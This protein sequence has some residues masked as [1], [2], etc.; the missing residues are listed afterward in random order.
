MAVSAETV[1]ARAVRVR[2]RV[3]GENSEARTGMS[4]IK[5]DYNNAAVVRRP[6]ERRRLRDDSGDA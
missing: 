5:R 6:V 4:N 2:L 3:E 1:R